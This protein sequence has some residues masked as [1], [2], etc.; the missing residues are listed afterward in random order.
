MKNVE[1]TQTQLNQ[2]Q[3]EIFTELQKPDRDA[4]KYERLWEQDKELKTSLFN[5]IRK[6]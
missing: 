2:V 4:T 6:K 1:Q 5:I 3:R